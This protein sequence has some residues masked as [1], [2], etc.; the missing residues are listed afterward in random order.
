MLKLLCLLF[1]V[2]GGL[3]GCGSSKTEYKKSPGDKPGGGG[4]AVA[5]TWAEMKDY[6]LTCHNANA[7]EIPTDE[8]GFQASAGVRARILNGSM[9][10]AAAK[11]DFD[12]AKAI[13]YLDKI[14]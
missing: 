5:Y 9:P 10:P 11:G 3:Q 4:D 2:L 12:A 14:R 13:A 7:P 1:G 8:A 6:C